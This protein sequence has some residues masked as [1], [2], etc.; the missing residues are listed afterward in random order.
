MDEGYILSNKYRKAIIDEIS[1]GEI[2][3]LRISKKHHIIPVITKRI[4]NEFIEGGILE[5]RQN[6]IFLTNKGQKI[7]NN[8][9]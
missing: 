5:K 9:T 6:K 1:S 8:I 7:V 4:V 3:I 2:D